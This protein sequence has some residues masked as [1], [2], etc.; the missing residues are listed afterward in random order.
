MSRAGRRTTLD[1]IEREAVRAGA[2]AVT[3]CDGGGRETLIQCEWDSI[4]VFVRVVAFRVAGA[5]HVVTSVRVGSAPWEAEIGG[6][7]AHIATLTAAARF[8]EWVRW[9]PV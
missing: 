8:A 3:P 1:E 5:S 6:L 2:V 7:F 4:T 9:Q